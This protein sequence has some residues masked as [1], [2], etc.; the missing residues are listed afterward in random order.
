MIDYITRLIH[1]ISS[2]HIFI[3][4]ITVI[5]YQYVRI[6]TVLELKFVCSISQW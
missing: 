1:N 4:I 6:C 5:L 2:F 3:K